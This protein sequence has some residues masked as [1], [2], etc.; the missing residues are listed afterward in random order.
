MKQLRKLFALLVAV[1]LIT[2]VFTAVLAEDAGASEGA[3]EDGSAAAAEQTEPKGE[4]NSGSTDDAASAGE[5][6]TS[7]TAEQPEQKQVYFLKVLDAK[8]KEIRS[9]GLLS[10]LGGGS[11]FFIKN[12][13]TVELGNVDGNKVVEA[14]EALIAS[15]EVADKSGSVIE[16]AASFE[17][18]TIRIS[19]VDKPCTIKIKLV[20]GRSF[21]QGS[22]EYSVPVSRFNLGLTD[23][24]LAAI[25]V[26][27]IVSA[28]RGSGSLFS[29]E[30]IKEDKKEQFKKL[31]RLLAGVTGAAFIASGVLS[32]CFSYLGW[33]KIARY[34]CLGLGLLSLIGILAVG[35]LMTDKEKKQ[36]AQQTA[37]TGGGNASSAAFEFDGTEPTIDDVLADLD[38][39]KNKEE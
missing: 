12:A 16:G 15:V 33:V 37:Q 39:K 22:G 4:D 29:D 23:I 24:L 26:Y 32:V 18:N 2:A 27:V 10:C 11:S 17:K 14:E 8:G 20:D 34:V 31:V 5:A 28:I 38:K 25:G 7:E 6:N 36:K 9:S 21:Y 13:Y 30:Y 35:S 1:M 3:A 19:P